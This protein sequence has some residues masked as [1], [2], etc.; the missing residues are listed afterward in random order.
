[1]PYGTELLNYM[2]FLHSVVLHEDKRPQTMVLY[3]LVDGF[4]FNVKDKKTPEN[5]EKSVMQ[6]I[7][8]CVLSFVFQIHWEKKAVKRVSLILKTE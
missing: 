6:L 7:Y 1:M 3:L 8:F 4:V 2:S 5:N